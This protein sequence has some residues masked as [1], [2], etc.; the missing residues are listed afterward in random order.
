L[1]YNTTAPCCD[2]AL[3]FVMPHKGIAR[4]LYN[5]RKECKTEKALQF[6]L[7]S[8]YKD[9]AYELSPTYIY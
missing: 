9:F 5:N 8:N 4:F 2:F 1:H 7:D 3:A 6:L